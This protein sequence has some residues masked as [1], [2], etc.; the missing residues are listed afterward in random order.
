MTI[1]SNTPSGSLISFLC[2]Q[3]DALT[4]QG[5]LFKHGQNQNTQSGHD[6]KPER[7]ELGSHRKS[8]L[9]IGVL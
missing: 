3:R 5:W 7:Q 1:P 8:S 2:A 4:L 9:K 6:V